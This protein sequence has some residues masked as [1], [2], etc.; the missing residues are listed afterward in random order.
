MRSRSILR[1]DK[2]R[3]DREMDGWLDRKGKIGQDRIDRTGKD[4]MGSN[5]IK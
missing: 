5:G 4:K 2:I 3:Y 1:K